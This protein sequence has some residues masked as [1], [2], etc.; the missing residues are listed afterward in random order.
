MSW[1][2]LVTVLV[3][4]AKCRNIGSYSYLFFSFA[5][6]CFCTLFYIYGNGRFF[7][8]NFFRSEWI[9]RPF[10]ANIFYFAKDVEEFLSKKEYSEILLGKIDKE[11]IGVLE[12]K[13]LS[14]KK[15]SYLKKYLIKL[16][17]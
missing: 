1:G 13:V 12:K 15:K 5:I 9:I 2:V 16:L 14:L 11:D 6:C 17:L 8:T 3:I 4:G 10:A 7:Y